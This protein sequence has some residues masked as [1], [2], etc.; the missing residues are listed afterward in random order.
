MYK[1][2][3][4]LCYSDITVISINTM[5]IQVDALPPTCNPTTLMVRYPHFDVLLTSL[6]IHV[7]SPIKWGYSA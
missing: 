7:K 1:Y 6:K 5:Y 2:R 3:L 4:M